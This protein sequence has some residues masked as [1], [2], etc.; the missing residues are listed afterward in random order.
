MKMVSLYQQIQM[1]QFGYEP[2]YKI[3]EGDTAYIDRLCMENEIN[4]VVLAKDLKLQ[5]PMEDYNFRVLAKTEEHVV[6]IRK[7]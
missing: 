1:I 6:Y 7:K 2:I 4:Y 5:Q 3:K